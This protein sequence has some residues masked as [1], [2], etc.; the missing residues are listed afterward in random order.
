MNDIET[1]ITKRRRDLGGEPFRKIA[2]ND[3]LNYDNKCIEVA[4]L[5]AV[6]LST[7]N[8]WLRAWS[9]AVVNE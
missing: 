9:K 1:R 3:T 2:T 7:A 8:N 6:S 5:Y 4:Q